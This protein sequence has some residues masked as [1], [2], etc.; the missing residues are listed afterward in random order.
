MFYPWQVLHPGEIRYVRR[1][2]ERLAG[3]AS[4]RSHDIVNF[5]NFIGG[6]PSARRLEFEAGDAT[7]EFEN[8]PGGV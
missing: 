5:M 4:A 2:M 6:S 8:D 3:R 7:S 1:R